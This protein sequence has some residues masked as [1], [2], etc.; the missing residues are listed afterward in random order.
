MSVIEDSF[1]NDFD[2][3]LMA[4]NYQKTQTNITDDYMLI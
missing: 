2:V 1:Q 4:S 3:S